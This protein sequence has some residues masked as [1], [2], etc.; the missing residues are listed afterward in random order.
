ML[1]GEILLP[2]GVLEGDIPFPDGGNRSL[3]AMGHSLGDAIAALNCCIVAGLAICV[4]S[5]CL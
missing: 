5:S 3:R 2:I 1:D 4:I